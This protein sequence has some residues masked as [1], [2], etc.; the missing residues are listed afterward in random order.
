MKRAARSALAFLLRHRAAIGAEFAELGIELLALPGPVHCDFVVPEIVAAD[1]QSSGR[2]AVVKHRD[3][4]V[5][6]KIIVAVLAA[7][8][9]RDVFERKGRCLRDRAGSDQRNDRYLEEYFAAHSMISSA[10]CCMLSG[11]ER[12]SALAVF[13]LIAISYLV[14]V[15]TGRSPGF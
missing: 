6:T 10:R 2:C 11:T 9:A 13:R 5:G 12:P 3:Q 4:H 1:L 14:G 7:P 8:F 15:C